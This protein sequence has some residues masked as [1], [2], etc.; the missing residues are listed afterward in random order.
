[1]S[2]EDNHYLVGFISG[3]KGMFNNRK[4]INIVFHINTLTKEDFNRM[5]S[6]IGNSCRKKIVGL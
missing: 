1:M 2:K 3:M 6:E 5:L 4:S